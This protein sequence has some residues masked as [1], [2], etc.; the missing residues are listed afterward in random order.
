MSKHFKTDLYT[1]AQMEAF[2][3]QVGDVLTLDVPGEDGKT[4]RGQHKVLEIDIG[5]EVS[6]PETGA[7]LTPVTLTLEG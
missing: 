4:V 3:I 6:H 5:R 1:E 7:T 2:S